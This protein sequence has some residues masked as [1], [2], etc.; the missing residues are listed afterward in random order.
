MENCIDLDEPDEEWQHKEH[1]WQSLVANIGQNGDDKSHWVVDPDKVHNLIEWLEDEQSLK[2]D[3]DERVV[4]E[5]GEHLAEV[6]DCEEQELRG[7]NNVPHV[8]EVSPSLLL[9]L[10]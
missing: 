7:I 1:Q 4:F 10:D 2:N 6:K 5:V 3:L 9:K 8:T